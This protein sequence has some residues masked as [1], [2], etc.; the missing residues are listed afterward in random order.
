MIETSDRADPA[1]TARR[2]SPSPVSR[3]SV[4]D[5]TWDV[6][7]AAP[8]RRNNVAAAPMIAARLRAASARST[9]GFSEFTVAPS[10]TVG[11]LADLRRRLG[12]DADLRGG[13]D[14][15]LYSA[16]FF[17]SHVGEVTAFIPLNASA[18]HSGGLLPDE[19]PV[20]V[21][22][23]KGPLRELD[24]TYAASGGF[25]AERGLGSR[26]R[27]AIQENYLVSGFDT[28]DEHGLVTEV[29]WP[30]LSTRGEKES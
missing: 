12:S 17:E 24:Q 2:R 8:S 26:A 10:A 27:T 13:P 22:V 15:A 9:S 23:H 14:G 4:N 11:V 20:A 16:E 28:D 19:G 25:V 6:R 30:V 1:T 18:G 29:C 21:A 7:V 3:S 5:L